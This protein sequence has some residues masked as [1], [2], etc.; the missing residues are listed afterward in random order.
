MESWNDT[1]K[2]FFL[3]YAPEHTFDRFTTPGTL[4]PEETIQALRFDNRHFTNVRI[5]KGIGD[6][7]LH[8]EIPNGKTGEE[9]ATTWETKN[10]AEEGYSGLRFSILKRTSDMD[11]KMS[12]WNKEHPDK[13]YTDCIGI[14]HGVEVG[15]FL[16]LVPDQ[17]QDLLNIN[18]Q[19][20]Y[21]EVS[22]EASPSIHNLKFP[23]KENDKA[24]MR[25]GRFYNDFGLPLTH[26]RL[27]I[28]TY[29]ISVKDMPVMQS[30]DPGYSLLNHLFK[31][32]RFG[33]GK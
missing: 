19:E 17:F 31:L 11:T 7:I 1:S 32:L 9:F 23:L 33:F 5:G 24:K 25:D 20:K 27:V 26:R 22:L 3:L 10:I 2:L 28:H 6:V 15:V 13:P 30:Q 21:L 29:E 16:Y 12:A 14:D 4:F 18:W 8:R